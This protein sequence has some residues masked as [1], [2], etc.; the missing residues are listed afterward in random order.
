VVRERR[1]IGHTGTTC[2]L[3]GHRGLALTESRFVRR[4]LDR[5]RVSFD[6]DS[7]VYERCK[8]CGAKHAIQMAA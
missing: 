6:A 1:V 3:C 8:E 4:G 5:L 7:R 2:P